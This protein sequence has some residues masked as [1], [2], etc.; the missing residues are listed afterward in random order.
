M[1]WP[2]LWV[3]VRHAESEGNLL[4][5][6]DRTRLE[7]GSQNYP[8]TERGRN[9]AI[10]TG[11]WLRKNF[12]T[13][14]VYYTSYYRRAKETLGLMYPS[15]QVFEDSRLAEAQRGIYHV[16]TEAEVG[17]KMPW[18]LERKG[19]EGLYHYRP[20]GG[21]NWADVEMRVHSFFGT[22]ARDCA[23]LRVLTIV[24]GHWLIL[25]RK[26]IEHFSIEEAEY[27]YRDRIVGNASVTVYRGVT[28]KGQSRLVLDTCNHIPWEGKI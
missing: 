2:S 19:R 4:S 21:E 26:L 25:A 11:R 27:E 9:Q 3:F 12:R 5:V 1:A 23:G 8:L 18:E 10:I 13:F 16:L 17:E 15:A 6:Q 22:V 7:V 24:H 14:D 28:R 20:P